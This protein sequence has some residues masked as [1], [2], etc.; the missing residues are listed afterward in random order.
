MTPAPPLLLQGKGARKV[1][2]MVGLLISCCIALLVSILL[3]EAA[4]PFSDWLL[5]GASVLFV[6]T[7]NCILLTSSTIFART[8][9]L[10]DKQAMA[11][12]RSSPGAA[13]QARPSV[14]HTPRSSHD[15]RASK[16][17]PRGSVSVRLESQDHT[18]APGLRED[19]DSSLLLRQDSSMSL[20][21]TSPSDSLYGLAL[22]DSNAN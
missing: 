13:S 12:S 4:G 3:V 5:L 11:R 2:R 17:T 21:G 7:Y 19:A 20:L 1:R 6:C 10:Q 14:L 16:G 8:R 22:D 18:N 15:S 9:K